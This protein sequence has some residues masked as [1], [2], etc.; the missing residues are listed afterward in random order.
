[1]RVR[2]VYGILA[3]ALITFAAFGINNIVK[4]KHTIQLKE[5]QI[6]DTNARLQSLQLQYIELNTQLESELHNKKKDSK[7]IEQLEQE[8]QRLEKEKQDLEAQLQA[9]AKR[10][11]NV[12]SLSQK[13]S[14]GSGCNTGNTYKDFIYMKES[15][16]NPSAVNS[17]GCRGIGQACP[18]SKLPCGADFAC[19]D[20]WFSNYAITR[21]GSWANAYS[22][23]LRN[24]WW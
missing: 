8:R 10:L 6:E 9:K 19:Q 18:G 1:M 21:Y 13:A 7:K 12:A 2:I 11:N 15:G 22:F 24:H 16:C 3:I 23:W 4:T 5:V 17:I 20:K 14:A